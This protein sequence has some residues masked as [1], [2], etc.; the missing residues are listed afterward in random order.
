MKSLFRP[1]ALVLALTSTSLLFA[2]ADEEKTP[3]GE[4]MS[5][6]NSAF[7]TLR[8]DAADATKSEANATLVHGMI[9]AATKSLEFKPEYTADQPAD[10]QAEFVANY[11]A[12]MKD[13]IAL[14]ERL[15]AAFKAGNTELAGEIMGELRPA[16]REAHGTYRRPRE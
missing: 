4:Q 13:F 14:L 6:I 8:S 11:Q 2:Q 15:E 7:R 10:Q 12:Q 9:E 3:L 5:A 16:Q 1:L